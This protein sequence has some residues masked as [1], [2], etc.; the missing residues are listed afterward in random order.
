MLRRSLILVHV[1]FAFCLLVG[2]QAPSRAGDGR[3]FLSGAYLA[4]NGQNTSVYI[5][6]VLSGQTLVGSGM[7]YVCNF[8]RTIRGTIDS[9]HV[10]AYPGTSTP[11]GAVLHA[12]V[13]TYDGSVCE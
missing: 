12:V 9:V 7:F 2:F 3:A 13:T 11:N 10:T 1:L 8:S 5:S 6:G 4:A